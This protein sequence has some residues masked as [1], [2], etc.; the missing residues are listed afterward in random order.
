MEPA[1]LSTTTRILW[2]LLESQNIDFVSLSHDCGLD[3]ALTVNPRATYP[4]DKVAKAWTDASLLMDLPSIGLE[5]AKFY[6]AT[7]LHALGYAF[8]ASSSLRTALARVVR[9]TAIINSYGFRVEE[10]EQGISLCS[11]SL[12]GLSSSASAILEDNRLSLI[13]AL[14][15]RASKEGFNPVAVALVHPEPEDTAPYY[16]FFRCPV[17]F[18]ASESRVSFSIQQA[19]RP[20]TAANHELARANDSVMANLV[21]SLQ[22]DDLVVKVKSAIIEELPSGEPAAETIAKSLCLSTRS[23]QRKLADE[24][25]TY[26][27]LLREVR[28]E[29]AEKYIADDTYAITE[30]SY[31]LGFSDTS[32]FSRA[33]KRWSGHPP[34]YF[35]K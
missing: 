5:S 31:L 3:P 35:R 4:V 30:I 23:L 21:K 34:G 7:D 27:K 25:T 22:K 29:L 15:R 20:F 14:C 6:R 24:G 28:Y 2:R 12:L 17:T 8:L 32:V 10:D 13:I 19:D 9:Y 11:P 18:G 33:F 26:T 16:G 1:F